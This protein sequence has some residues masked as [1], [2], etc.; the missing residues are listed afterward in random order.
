MMDE[1]PPSMKCDNCG[2]EIYSAALNDKLADCSNVAEVDEVREEYDC[3]KC[4]R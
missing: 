4:N 1:K 2:Y 3:P